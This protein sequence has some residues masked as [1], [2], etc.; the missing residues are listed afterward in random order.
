MSFRKAA[1]I[2][3]GAAVAAA[4]VSQVPSLGQVRRMDLAAAAKEVVS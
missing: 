3:A 2:A 4:V 1:W